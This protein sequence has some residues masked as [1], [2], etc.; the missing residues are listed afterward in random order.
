MLIVPEAHKK[1]PGYYLGTAVY[2][3]DACGS[4]FA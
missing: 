3:T 2:N 1:L 4:N